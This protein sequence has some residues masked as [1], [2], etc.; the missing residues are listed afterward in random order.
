MAKVYSEQISDELSVKMYPDG[1]IEFRNENNDNEFL[2]P[3]AA[4]NK[5]GK[6]IDRLAAHQNADAAARGKK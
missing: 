3:A 2:I 4:I 5:M 6:A 1:A